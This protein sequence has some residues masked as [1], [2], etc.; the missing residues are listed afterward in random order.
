VVVTLCDC[1]SCASSTATKKAGPV[2][3]CIWI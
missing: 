1:R 2:S 3:C